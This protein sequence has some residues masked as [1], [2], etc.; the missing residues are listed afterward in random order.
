[1]LKKLRTFYMQGLIISSLVTVL[2]NVNCAFS[3]STDLFT[4]QKVVISQQEPFLQGI[5]SAS[6]FLYLGAYKLHEHLLPNA[7]IVEALEG[8]AQRSDL[9]EKVDVILE[10][11]LTPEE[12]TAGINTVN[13]GDSFQSYKNLGIKVV[14]GSPAFNATH[15][16]ILVSDPYAFIGTTNFD[17][18]YEEDDLITRDFS[19]IF[20]QPQIIKE[21]K[22]VFENDVRQ[23]ESKFKKYVVKDINFGETRLTWGPN[24]HRQHL[25]QLINHASESIEIY[26]QALQ[27]EVITNLL[28]D[29]IK[30]GVKVSVL[31]S[32]FP[33]GSKHGNKSEHDQLKIS[34]ASANNPANKSEVRLTGQQIEEGPL[35][36]KKLHIHAKVMIVDGGNPQKAIMYLGSANFYTPALDKD[37]NVGVVTRDQDYIQPVRQQFVQDWAAHTK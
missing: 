2:I 19:L 11:N 5:R 33:F 12:Q 32:Q 7:R 28:V 27:D 1:M 21:L 18:D 3:S 35:K 6:G 15:F 22:T 25:E 36:G 17:K 30:R 20:T 31:M 8:V 37:R 16:K 10:S 26:Q 23:K 13:E 14:R 29:A 24:Q 4:D 34:E 9:K